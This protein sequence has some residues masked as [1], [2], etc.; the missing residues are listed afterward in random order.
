MLEHASDDYRLHTTRADNTYKLELVDIS[1]TVTRVNVSIE[2]LDLHYRYDLR[3]KNV[4]I[5]I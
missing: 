4:S 5:I 3:F 2:E 1:L